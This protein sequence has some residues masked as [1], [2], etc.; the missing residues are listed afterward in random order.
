MKLMSKAIQRRRRL[1]IA[2]S[3]LGLLAFSISLGGIVVMAVVGEWLISAV[4]GM[5]GGVGCVL[6]AL[7]GLR[8]MVSLRRPS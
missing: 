8:S 1:W 7:Y 4:G 6:A 2:V 3:I 5:I